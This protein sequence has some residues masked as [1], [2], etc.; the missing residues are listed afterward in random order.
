M[1]IFSRFTITVHN[2]ENYLPNT[3]YNIYQVLIDIYINSQTEI[4]T[5][6]IKDC[7]EVMINNLDSNKEVFE[8]IYQKLSIY[9]R[10]K[11]ENRDQLDN[12][13]FNKYLSLLK[14]LY[15]E[16]LNTSRPGN[17]F[18][19]SG[20]GA[21]RLDDKKLSEDKI[22][23]NQGCVISFWFKLDMNEANEINNMC[24]LLLIKT[25]KDTKIQV[26]LYLNKLLIRN[27][28]DKEFL[29]KFNNEWNHFS[30][31][32]KPKSIRRNPEFIIILN[33]GIPNKFTTTQLD[34]ECEVTEIS[35]FQNFI[36][37]ATS[38]MFMNK[39]VT[40]DYVKL[41]K[42]ISPFG[43]YNEKKLFRF[44]RS[45]YSKYMTNS[46]IVVRDI[47]MN[48]KDSEGLVNLIENMKMFYVPFRS[49]ERTVYDCLGKYNA[50]FVSFDCLNSI[51]IY[52]RF[53]KN[54]FF[55]GGINNILPMIELMHT[56]GLI[57]EGTFYNTMELIYII[58]NYRIKNMKDAVNKNFF[59]MLSLFIEKFPNKIFNERI[60][61]IF[62]TL[63]KGLFTFVD[64]CELSTVYF[65]YILLNEKVFTK[66]D[67]KLQIELWKSLYQ[68]YVSDASQIKNFMKMSKICIVVHN[69]L[70]Y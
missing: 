2:N 65:D 57:D 63:G 5:N 47:M 49:S 9:Y 33:D 6:S 26:S 28:S 35:F 18:Y 13:L 11:Q 44:M 48:Q 27:Y 15:G 22:K 14:V 16:R 43:I 62:I 19:F 30:L 52:N 4:L 39:A 29:H 42:D 66:F 68:F 24:D 45:A 61:E 46:N 50:H 40:E 36:G 21:L 1:E 64:Q 60:M 69:I 38:I 20:N 7:L 55:V 53:Q 12:T 56:Q 10:M 23:L 67:I 32:I 58:L 51:H 41:L 3:K 25:N 37:Q 54:I 70:I 59:Q 17:Y 31:I 8:F 34:L